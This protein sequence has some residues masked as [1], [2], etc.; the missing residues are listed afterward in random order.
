MSEVSTLGPQEERKFSFLEWRDEEAMFRAEHWYR[1]ITAHFE[2]YRIQRNSATGK[3]GLW[4]TIDPNRVDDDGILRHGLE[5]LVVYKR[6]DDGRGFFTHFPA[7]HSL[8][9]DYM[10]AGRR[11][12]GD[13]TVVAYLRDL[14]LAAGGD[15]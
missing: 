5:C 13:K 1:D 12:M 6:F 14:L 15:F 3:P 4:I 10:P 11:H 9:A 7:P 8:P 2:G